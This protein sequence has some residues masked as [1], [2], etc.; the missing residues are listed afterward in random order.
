MS[1]VIAVGQRQ[2]YALIE[3]HLHRAAHEGADRLFI[4]V[5]RIFH[6]LDLSAVGEF[7]EPVFEVL[8]LDRRDI[9]RHMAV[10]TIADIL[11]VGDILHDPVFFPELLDLK[12]TEVFRRCRVD[13]IEVSVLVFKLLHLL[14]DVL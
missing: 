13:R 7:P 2:V 4:V 5:D 11:A 12:S 1:A 9:F 10:E 6:V 3:S 8:L 14:I